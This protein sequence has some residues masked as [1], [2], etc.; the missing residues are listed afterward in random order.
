M[1]NSK[2][3]P[4]IKEIYK[5]DNFFFFGVSLISMFAGVRVC[6]YFFYDEKKLLKVRE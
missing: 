3:A 4:R 6:D 2:F 5:S 1:M